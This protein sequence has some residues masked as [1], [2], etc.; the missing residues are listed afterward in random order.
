MS[1]R[2]EGPEVGSCSFCGL[3]APLT[4]AGEPTYCCF[5]CRFAAS[6]AASQGD[7]AQARWAMTR[8]GLAV[9]FSMNVM[10]FTMLL[11][12][13]PAGEQGALASV[14]YDLARYASLLFTLPVV[15]ML[16]GPLAGDAVAELSRGRASISL[17]LLVGVAAALLSSIWSLLQGAGHVYFEVACTILVATTLGRWFEATGK[18]KTT[19]ALRSLARLMPN[20]VR[21]LKGD[22]ETLVPSVEL[23]TGDRFRVLAGERIAADG[24]I[25][26]HQAS[27][28][29]Q[30][31]SGESL[32]VTRG[33]GDGVLSGMLVLDVPLEIV[34]SASAGEGMLARIVAAVTEATRARSRYERLAEQISR[35]FLPLVAAV[36]I[37]ALAL[38]WW[39][40][41]AAAGLLAALAVLT[42]ACPCALG[43][44][45]PMALWAAIGRAAQAG[46]LVREGDVLSLLARAKTVCFD[47]TGTLTTGDNR[48]AFARFDPDTDRCEVVCVAAALADCNTHPLSVAVAQYLAD[49]LAAAPTVEFT[50]VQIVPGG[51]VQAQADGL[52]E[53]VFLGSRQWL[54][55][56]GQ[57]F[58]NSSLN[59]AEDEDLCETLIAWGGRTRGRFLIRQQVRPEAP[60]TIADLHA[61]GL[62]SQVLTGDRQSRARSLGSELGLEVRAELRPDD[63]LASILCLQ[64]SGP[65]VM[66]GDGINDAPA[67]AAADVGISL[68]SGTDI[69]RHTAGVC[70]LHDN[71]LLVP[72]LV[73]L[74]GATV[75]TVRWNL[76]WAFAYNVLGIGLAACGWLHPVFAAIAMAVSGL[77]VV[78]NSLALAQFPLPPAIAGD[79]QAIPEADDFVGASHPAEAAA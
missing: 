61:L 3:P 36:A 4:A 65:V 21:L 8:L 77:L 2:R 12:S 64:D 45:T 18:L 31:V 55:D 14:W 79:A 25:V 50:D 26:R 47:K 7:E 39:L 52:G 30:V 38:H 59:D 23:C 9:F 66:V 54:A 42:I 16:G 33:P 51:G 17:L 34:A 37:G 10:V 5:G 70:L 68:A 49:D 75:R 35:W 22:R 6:I 27:I 32:P 11:W 15:L 1:T 29:E 53:T 74:A 69:S 73:R 57:A 58:L 62:H 13:Q 71:L 60:A 28:D 20:Q 56:C 67:L 72:W 48:V 43:L 46:V 76:V 24:Q 41:D 40:G 44:A 78:G 19:E 63:K